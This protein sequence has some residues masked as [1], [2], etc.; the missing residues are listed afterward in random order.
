VYLIA[1]IFGKVGTEDT[2]K[3]K[4]ALYATKSFPGL[5]GNFGFDENGDVTNIGMRITQI[6]D[7][8]LVEV[9]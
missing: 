2:S 3:I 1:S 4:Q 5:T 8:G 9:K 7:G 6:K